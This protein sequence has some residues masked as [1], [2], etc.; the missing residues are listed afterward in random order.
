MSLGRWIRGGRTCHW[1]MSRC[2]TKREICCR[3]ET[4]PTRR[5]MA[6][7]WWTARRISTGTNRIGDRTI[8]V[9]TITAT[10][11]G[12]FG[13]GRG[14]RVFRMTRW[15][16]GLRRRSISRRWRAG[17]TSRCLRLLIRSGPPSGGISL[18][19]S[20]SRRKATTA[21]TISKRTSWGMTRCSLASC[22]SIAT[23]SCKLS[24]ATPPNP[25]RASD[26]AKRATC[27][28]TRTCCARPSLRTWMRTG[29]TRSSPRSRTTLTRTNT[30][31][32]P[33]SKTSMST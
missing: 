26:P 22:P 25:P 30:P 8:T 14:L 3:T 2:L 27:T 11:M 18:L 16:R 31:I 33:P 32:P 4:F 21:P 6:R 10:S 12:G 7:S 23:S 13:R 19:S 9:T 17:W 5:R 20:T 15:Q 28:S 1:E 29:G 24:A